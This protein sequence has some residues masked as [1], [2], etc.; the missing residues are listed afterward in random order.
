MPNP[1]ASEGLGTR[2]GQNHN[3]EARRG[4]HVDPAGHASY[5]HFYSLVGLYVKPSF[6]LL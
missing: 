3:P 2:G 6:K 4:I 5:G 1:Q